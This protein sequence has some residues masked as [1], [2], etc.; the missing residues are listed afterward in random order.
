MVGGCLWMSL[1]A[2]ISKTP[3]NWHQLDTGV[4][5][6]M[7]YLSIFATLLT[8][9]LF[10][11]TTVKLG[12]NKVMAYIYLNPATIII[13][14]FIFEAKSINIWTLIGICISSIATVLILSWNSKS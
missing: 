3:L 14:Q 2:I 7:A 6:Y 8:A 10:Q 1:T 5:L 9:Y 13:L 4:I 12:P 11:S